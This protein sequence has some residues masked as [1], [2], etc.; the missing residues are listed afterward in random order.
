MN[1]EKILGVIGLAYRAKKIVTGEE[2]S[3][4]LI[5]GNAAKMVFLASDTA[6][7]TTKRVTDK[8]KYYQVL[9]IN[10]FTTE[11]LSKAVGRENIKVL[12]L[13]CPNFYQLISN[14]LEK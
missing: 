14:Y 13:S 4:K 8:C 7:S 1:K 6:H 2:S 11:E 3:L 5:K 10:S 9:L 12:G